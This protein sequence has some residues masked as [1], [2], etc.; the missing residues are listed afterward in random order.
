MTGSQFVPWAA[1]S[2]I[3]AA[4]LLEMEPL[5][6]YKTGATTITSSTAVVADP[7]LQ[8]NLGIGVY[9]FEMFVS[10]TGAATGTGDLKMDF[11]YTGSF[12]TSAWTPFGATISSVSAM[13][14][15]SPAVGGGTQSVGS[16][17]TSVG[18]AAK[19]VGLIATSTAGTL[20]WRWAQNTSSATATT[21]RAGS[22]LRVTQYG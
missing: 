12:T 3:T 8:V 11:N 5:F 4:G 6:A 21:V 10:Y 9:A 19:P 2:K 22:W 13:N 17:G 14:V 7:D 20:Q 16:D 15:F 1:G 18:M